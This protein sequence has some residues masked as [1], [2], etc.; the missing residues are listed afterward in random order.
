MSNL[1]VTSTSFHSE[2][3]VGPLTSHKLF[4]NCVKSVTVLTILRIFFPAHSVTYF[5][6]NLHNSFGVT[7][8]LSI[9]I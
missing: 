6:V 8:V 2:L 3:P 9:E 5:W 1:E 7:L 4:L